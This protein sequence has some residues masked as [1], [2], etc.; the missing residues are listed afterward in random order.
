DICVHWWEY[1]VT[2]IM[3]LRVGY[4]TGPADE[5][6]GLTVGAGFRAGRILLDYAFVPYGDLGNTHRISLGM[7]F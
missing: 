3:A 2:N 1:W 4:R 5:G 6:S 7:K